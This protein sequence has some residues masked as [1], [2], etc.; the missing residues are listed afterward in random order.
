MDAYGRIIDVRD[1]KEEVMR[2]YQK[3]G[4]GHMLWRF[5]RTAPPRKGKEPEYGACFSFRRVPAADF[6]WERPPWQK[7]KKTG[8]QASFRFRCGPVPYTGKAKGS[9]ERRFRSWFGTFRKDRIPEYRE[10]ARK[11][12]EIPDPY[13]IEPFERR[14]KCWKRQSKC[15]HQWQ[16]RSRHSKREAG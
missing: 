4:G 16:V 5:R 14:E 10:Y 3:K 11:G 6:W 13:D 8:Q 2:R 9:P 12:A 7:K 1:L 15:R